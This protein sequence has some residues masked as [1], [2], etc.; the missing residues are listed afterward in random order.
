MIHNISILDEIKKGGY[1]ASLIT[2]FNAYLP[3]YEEVVL[4]KLQSVGVRYN[5]LMMDARQCSHAIQTAPPRLAGYHYPLIPIASPESFHPK[6]IFLV[7]KRKGLL[8]V[9]SH[10]MTLAGFG[11]NRELSNV[12]HLHDPGDQETIALFVSAWTQ[13]QGW[14]QEQQFPRELLE[15]ISHV[16][17]FALW[18]KS[19]NAKQPSDTFI[20]S[21]QPG[22]ASL[23]EQ[24]LQFIHPPVT[25]VMLLGAFFDS[26][27]QFLKRLQ[28][29][30]SPQECIVGIDP[31]TVQAP[32]SLQAQ[33]G[34]RVVKIEEHL[35]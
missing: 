34:L 8:F 7:G 32:E 26:R 15:M 28:Q 22:S 16:T 23:W 2:T 30:L 35:Y 4:R 25:R 27:L 5:V 9:G 1:E 13:I 24:L 6:V 12:I 11:F 31:E 14:I 19:K 21:S 17:S 29:D 10:N 33:E 20:I 3:F 18:L